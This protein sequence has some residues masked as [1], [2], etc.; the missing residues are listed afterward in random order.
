MITTKT[1]SLSGLLWEIGEGLDRAHSL[2][3][4]RVATSQKRSDDLQTA[5]F[6]RCGA[7]GCEVSDSDSDPLAF[8]LS[9]LIGKAERRLGVFQE[10]LRLIH[11]A[12]VNLDLVE[13]VGR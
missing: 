8:R 13:L 11:E 1:E 2:M 5:R 9:E 4:G 7:L 3:R 6:N 10:R 12:R